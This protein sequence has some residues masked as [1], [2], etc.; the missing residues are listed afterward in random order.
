MTLH[1]RSQ[2]RG[3]ALAEASVAALEY[4]IPVVTS[5]DQ[6][7]GRGVGGVTGLGGTDSWQGPPEA[8]PVAAASLFDDCPLCGHT[9]REPVFLAG[10]MS[11]RGCTGSCS[12]CSD[13]CLPGDEACDECLRML[14]LQAVVA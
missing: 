12:I 2:G 4:Q 3:Y 14:Y 5:A 6:P 1:G 9:P 7:G 8:A 11:C 13:V 10:Q